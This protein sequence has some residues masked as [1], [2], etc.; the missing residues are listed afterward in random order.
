[1]I[2]GIL[3]IL[4]QN[5]SLSDTNIS[6]ELSN[7]D[8]T[9]YLFQTI[10]KTISNVDIL[11]AFSTDHFLVFCSFIK[12]LNSTKDPGFW[13]FNNLSICDSNFVYEMKTFIHNSLKSSQTKIIHFPTKVNG[14]F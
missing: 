13:K 1:M 11:N 7:L 10:F 3:E 9:T 8:W 4:K 14:D 5:L 2:F 6:P 12:C